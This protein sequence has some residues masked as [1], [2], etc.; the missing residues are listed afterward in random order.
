MA[1][2]ILLGSGGSSID[3]DVLTATP[4]KVIKSLTFLGAGSDE[5]QTGTLEINYANIAVGVT[6]LGKTGTY[7]GKGNA[8][9]KQ[10]LIGYTAS[11][12]NKSNFAGELLN[13]GALN[14]TNVGI[15]YNKTL[16]AGYYSSIKVTQ[17]LNKWETDSN[18]HG[19]ISAYGGVNSG[20]YYRDST[21]G[22]GLAVKVKNYSRLIGANW[23]F[24]AMPNLKPENIKN[25][26]SIFGITGTA[27]SPFPDEDVFLFNEGVWQ[28]DAS[29]GAVIT[30]IEEYESYPNGNTHWT[31]DH[32]DYVS[33][34][35]SVG[36]FGIAN[37]RA[38]DGNLYTEGNDDDTAKYCGD[39]GD[40]VYVYGY[41]EDGTNRFRDVDGNIRN[42]N[43][44]PPGH[45]IYLHVP[46]KQSKGIKLG[47]SRIEILTESYPDNAVDPLVGETLQGYLIDNSHKLR[48]SWSYNM[49]GFYFKYYPRKTYSRGTYTGLRYLDIFQ[50]PRFRGF[51]VYTYHNGRHYVDC[52]DTFVELRDKIDL[53]PYSDIVLSYYLVESSVKD[54]AVSRTK[55]SYTVH[56]SIYLYYTDE[57]TGREKS[58]RLNNGLTYGESLFDAAIGW[59]DH[60]SGEYN[61]GGDPVVASR[62]IKIAKIPSRKY[63]IKFHFYNINDLGDTRVSCDFK[64]K[65]VITGIKLIPGQRI[66]VNLDNLYGYDSCKKSGYG[67]NITYEY[68]DKINVINGVLY[69]NQNST[70]DTYNVLD[71][72]KYYEGYNGKLDPFIIFKYGNEYY[73][74]ST[75]KN[76]EVTA[77]SRFIPSKIGKLYKVVEVVRYL[78]NET[79]Y[80]K[81]YSTYICRDFYVCTGYNSLTK[82]EK[83]Y[84]NPANG[85][86]YS[87]I[88]AEF[89]ITGKIKSLDFDNSI[90]ANG[91]L[92]KVYRVY[93]A[94]MSMF[95]GYYIYNENVQGKREYLLYHSR[96]LSYNFYGYMKCTGTRTFTYVNGWDYPIPED[97]PVAARVYNIGY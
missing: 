86:I 50:T 24:L 96:A 10:V 13:R 95:S 68:S 39:G 19:V 71:W 40:F 20:V 53:S 81:Y 1:K 92:N 60:Y 34:G 41:V 44:D 84:R 56:C 42:L 75:V 4:P 36:P 11:N 25:G 22:I 77:K 37:T 90:L 94:D 27:K 16:E 82:I 83:L 12:N 72:S 57:T 55:Y 17:S 35:N 91:S 69:V 38:G 2:C 30:C 8:G 6:I 85:K 32:S 89:S 73:L 74:N 7:T 18:M 88:K 58:I 45:K 65:C 29:S 51:Y 9:P 23:V 97:N 26:V 66:F 46:A 59:E 15:N 54:K 52:W 48:K 21:R 28:G 79:E 63:R 3:E 49:Y 5:P 70:E 87:E 80:K 76:N 43:L 67:T 47:Q 64:E 31:A 14:N 93:N 78:Y 61:W 62:T 33:Y